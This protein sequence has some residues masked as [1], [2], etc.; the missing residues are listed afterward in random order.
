MS[1]PPDWPRVMPL[2]ALL[3]CFGT[4]GC[5]TSG[6]DIDVGFARLNLEGDVAL[7]PSSG[8]PVDLGAIENDLERSFG[9]DDHARTPY[10]GVKVW[11]EKWSA[12]VSTLWYGKDSDGTLDNDY[13]DILQS[14]AVSTS[15]DIINLKT[16]VHYELISS[17]SF[18]LSP[19]VGIE[20][21]DLDIGATSGALTQD[22]DTLVVMP[23]VFLKAELD[24]GPFTLMTDVG[25]FSADLLGVDGTLVDF[26]A[27]LRLKPI[28]LVEVFG[29]YRAILLDAEGESGSQDFSTDFLLHGWMIG[30]ELPF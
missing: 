6:F 14:T 12:N 8:V 17:D 30:V 1:P 22:I 9:L 3:A 28:P 25:A 21:L 5:E 13:G 4:G 10:F 11:H 16:A 20:L 26:E 23:M 24:V 18:R 7:G 29:G 15:A 27:V 2:V 19:G